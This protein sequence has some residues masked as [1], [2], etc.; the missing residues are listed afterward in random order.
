MGSLRMERMF[1]SNSL[2]Q[3]E[4]GLRAQRYVYGRGYN[5]PIFVHVCIL[6][7]DRETGLIPIRGALTTRTHNWNLISVRTDTL[8]ISQ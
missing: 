2:D 1:K 7:R 3:H 4:I 8:Y 6:H 5:K